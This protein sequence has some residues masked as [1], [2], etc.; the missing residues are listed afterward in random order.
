MAKVIA[1]FKLKGAIGDIVFYENEYGP[2]ARQKGSPTEWHIKHQDSFKNALRTGAEWKRATAAAKLLRCATGGLLKSVTGM[3]TNGHFNKALLSA[4]KADKI[5]GLG[6]RV[7]GSGNPGLLTGLELSYKLSLDD[8]L[9]LNPE[10]CF[11]VEGG[12]ISL[13]MPA[14]RLRKKKA[15]PDTATH[16]RLVSA[17][18]RID[19]EKNDYDRDIKAGPLQAMGRKAGEA[20]SV[21]HLLAEDTVDRFWL[22]GIEFYKVENGKQTLVKGGGALRVM[23]WVKPVGKGREKEN[24]GDRETQ[25]GTT[26]CMKEVGTKEQ[27]QVVMEPVAKNESI[28]QVE[29]VEK[30]EVVAQGLTI[31]LKWAPDVAIAEPVLMI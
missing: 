9:P 1:P 15:L 17:V 6:E 11:T 25:C 28:V 13:Q 10:H 7:I 24:H 23:Q 27:A 21:E 4:I 16:Y 3:G 31:S 29:V 26:D 30:A 12:N 22:L 5:H 18:L 2:Q 14:F 19:F 20:F 8:A